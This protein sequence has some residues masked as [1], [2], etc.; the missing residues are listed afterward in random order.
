MLAR[1]DPATRPTSGEFD[2]AMDR[3]TN[4]DRELPAASPLE[5]LL[6]ELN[7]LWS[8]GARRRI[9]FTEVLGA[10]GIKFMHTSRWVN[11]SWPHGVRVLAHEL[12]LAIASATTH[13]PAQIRSSPMAGRTQSR[14]ESADA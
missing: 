9:A 10:Q 5:R 11:G 13:S 14:A 7:D 1:P 6:T 3:T 8:S 4:T 12:G 2:N